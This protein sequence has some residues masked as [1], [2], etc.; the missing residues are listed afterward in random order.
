MKIKNIKNR[1]GLNQYKA[2]LL[3]IVVFKNLKIKGNRIS[4]SWDEKKFSFM[5]NKL[6]SKAEI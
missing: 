6:I 3:Q 2:W 5:K 4:P 1:L